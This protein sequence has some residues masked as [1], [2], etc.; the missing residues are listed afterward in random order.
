[1]RRYEN[2]TWTYPI[3]NTLFSFVYRTIYQLP[4]YQRLTDNSLAYEASLVGLQLQAW[5]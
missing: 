1:M 2:Q 4:L 3:R 5:F